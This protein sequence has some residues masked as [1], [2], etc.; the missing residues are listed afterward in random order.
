MCFCNGGMACLLY[1]CYFPPFFRNLQD[2]LD[3]EDDVL[4]GLYLD[5]SV[6]V[7]YCMPSEILDQKAKLW[8]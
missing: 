7:F 1:K 3:Y 6:G 5:F 8:V 4:E 2:V